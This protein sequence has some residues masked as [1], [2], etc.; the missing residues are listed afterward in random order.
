MKFKLKISFKLFFTIFFYLKLIWIV[1][2]CVNKM[3]LPA[4]I[5][6]DVEFSAGDTTF[7]PMYP[8]W[9]SELG[10]QNP[11]EIS[12]APDGHIF[13]ADSS[14]KSIFVLDLSGQLLSGFEPLVSM[15]FQ[16]EP[17]HPIDVD[18]DNKM[19]V[20]FIDGSQ[21]IFRW[22]QLWKHNRIDSYSSGGYFLTDAGTD[23]FIH[24]HKS[25]W[26]EAVNN[27]QWELTEIMWEENPII[28]DSLV[29]FHIVYDGNS[30]D[31]T[32]DIWYK[33]TES[34]FSGLTT[35]K[36]GSGTLFV[37]DT[38]HHRILALDLLR[39]YKIRLES[40]EEFWTHKLSFGHTV[41]EYGTGSGT[42]NS[43]KGIDMDEQGN[44]Y[45]A[46]TGDYFHVHKI[47]PILSGTY[48][49]YPSEFQQGIHDIM[50][51][52]RFDNPLDVA[53]DKHQYIYVAN[54]S[55][56]EIQV[57]DHQGMYFKKAGVDFETVDTTLW[58]MNDTDSV[59]TDTFLIVEKKNYLEYPSAVAVDSRGV[60]YV[61]DSPTGS[62]IRFR[63]SNQLDENLIPVK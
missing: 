19:N 30:Q 1:E 40:G 21:R 26:I 5:E 59:K 13:V 2:G 55:E 20:F 11:V 4:E 57:F 22:N 39:S 28:R 9:G 47:K 61:C 52:Y 10:L 27:P 44:L 51:L 17:I 14:A 31:T 46:Q 42:V 58:V 12:I 37:T 7:L 48:P 23:S 25:A 29:N 24:S 49:V 8:I 16:E 6:N 32:G 53:V 56:K 18:V 60:I 41:S 35:M 3:E 15:W 38:R 34:E 62:I 54:T 50:E 45:Y 33:S 63:L 36:E 43:P